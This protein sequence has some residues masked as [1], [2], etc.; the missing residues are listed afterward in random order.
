MTVASAKKAVENLSQDEWNDFLPW[1]VGE[2]RNR[3][4]SLETQSEVEVELIRQMRAEGVIE[5]PLDGRSPCDLAG[6]PVEYKEG[7]IYLP[8]ESVEYNGKFY[9]VACEGATNS[10]PTARNSDWELIKK[11]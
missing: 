3:R 9:M 2:E 10:K 1:V 5:D 8:G 4:L 7:L 11:D 6:K